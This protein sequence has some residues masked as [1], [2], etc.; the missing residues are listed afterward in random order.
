MYI[1]IYTYTHTYTH[2]HI[3]THSILKPFKRNKK[4]ISWKIKNHRVSHKTS[5]NIYKVNVVYNKVNIYINLT[6]K[7]KDQYL[8]SQITYQTHTYSS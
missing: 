2:I 6:N 4:K 7:S 8:K 1:Y 5:R 3:H